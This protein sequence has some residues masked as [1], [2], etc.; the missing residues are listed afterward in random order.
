[1]QIQGSK[2]SSCSEK[3][4]SKDQKSVLLR[5]NTAEPAK[6]KDKKK[7]FRRHKRKCIG[8]QKEQTSAIG[9]NTT[10]APTKKIQGQI[11]QIE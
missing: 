8:K 5:N 1:M 9:V 2:D 7:R 6:K 11:L 3:P 4:K 10:K